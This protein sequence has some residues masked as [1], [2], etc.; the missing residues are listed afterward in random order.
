MSS[1]FGPSK[2]DPIRGFYTDLQKLQIVNENESGYENSVTES[3]KLK[4][5]FDKS[6]EYAQKTTDIGKIE[7]IEKAIQKISQTI[8]DPKTAIIIQNT[9]LSIAT[10]S[11]KITQ[12]DKIDLSY[13]ALLI[14]QDIHSQVA[15]EG[16][17]KKSILET[18][19]NIYLEL[20]DI[21]PSSALE[22]LKK[23]CADTN[24]SIQNRSDLKETISCLK[25]CYKEGLVGFLADAKPEVSF[26][27]CSQIEKYGIENEND[28]FQIALAIA[29]KDVKSIS[30]NIDKF[31]IQNAQYLHELAILIANKSPE[32]FCK[33][34][35]KFKIV[36]KDLLFKLAKIVADKSPRILCEYLTEFQIQTPQYLHELAILIAN[37]SPENFC[38][39]IS[40]FKIVD[41][42]L[43]FKLAKIVANKSPEILC[44]HLTEFQ[45]QNAQYLHE[46][47]TLIANESPET[48]CKNIFKFKKI[49]KDILFELAKIVADKNPKILCQYLTEFQI[50]TPQYLHEL[51][52]LIANKSPEILCQYLTE[53]QIQNSQYLHEL[54]TLIANESPETF[55]KNIFKF[56]KFG[57]DI[58]FELA[59]IVAD[60]NPKILCEYLAEF[61]IENKKH[62]YEIG[63]IIANKYPILFCRHV[64][65]FINIENEDL[66]E[67]AIIIADKEPITFCEYASKLEIN[68]EDTLF[69]IANSIIQTSINLQFFCKNIEKF[70]IK[71]P[72]K[73]FQLAK[74]V[75]T[76]DPDSFCRNIKKFNISNP[77][78]RYELAQLIATIR[79]ASLASNINY[80]DIAESKQRYELAKLIAKTN[81]A[82]VCDNIE[83]FN[84][85]DLNERLE[86]LRIASEFPGNAYVK[87]FEIPETVD[88]SEIAR[89]FAEHSPLN[90]TFFIKDF[91]IKN[92]EKL[93]EIAKTCL[94]STFDSRCPIENFSSDSYSAEKLREFNRIILSY[95][96][97]RLLNDKGPLEGEFYLGLDS[98]YSVD[99]LDID[100]AK[101]IYQS[102]GFDLSERITVKQLEKVLNKLRESD[103]I[104]TDSEKLTHIFNKILAYTKANVAAA[105][106]GFMVLYADSP[107]YHLVYDALSSKPENLP[108]KSKKLGEEKYPTSMFLPSIIPASWTEDPTNPKISHLNRF[109]Y[110]NRNIFKDYRKELIHIF[111]LTALNLNKSYFNFSNE[112][113]LELLSAACD[114]K[115]LDKTIISLKCILYFCSSLESKILNFI[116]LDNFHDNLLDNFKT[117]IK[118]YFKDKGDEFAIKLLDI[119]TSSRVSLGLMLYRK[120]QTDPSVL[121]S[122]DL[123]I[124]SVISGNF[125]QIRTDITNNPHLQY[126]K[127]QTPE[128]LDK[129]NA[130]E[131]E[132]KITNS[133]KT[134]SSINLIDFFK[135]KLNDHHFTEIQFPGLYRRLNPEQSIGS[136]NLRISELDNLIIELV[137]L[138]NSSNEKFKESLEEILLNWNENYPDCELKNDLKGLLK[139]INSSDSS[140]AEKAILTRDW[141]DLFLCGTDVYGSC[142]RIDGT[143]NENQCLMAYCLDGKNQMIAIKSADGKEKKTLARAILRLLWDPD[144]N[145]PVLFLERIYPNLSPQSRKEGILAAAKEAAKKLNCELIS[146]LNEPTPE[147]RKAQSFGS[148]CSHEYVDGGAGH[149]NGSFIIK[150]SVI[151]LS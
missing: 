37:K 27:I 134:P 14:C 133:G 61:Q 41:K 91:K 147:Q 72:E 121:E 73:C 149:S 99:Q 32:D 12:K 92:P 40:K 148:C 138:G 63:K 9:L 69:K 4:Y 7:K 57:K 105:L 67:I 5:L 30:K 15:E 64:N 19:E 55:C 2:Q 135:E 22:N 23:I 6:V 117:E 70:N 93:L 112:R 109:F 76:K 125:P 151:D 29:S 26:K 35:S 59:K 104:L 94:K 66:S 42:D 123:F 71:S 3:G 87:K 33:N 65:I 60:K 114:P 108:T 85:E 111:L 47:A 90:L 98:R 143:E 56:K 54:A 116:E 34:I 81:S 74:L 16:M 102:L 140:V 36:D 53:F 120:N 82:A 146:N 118:K 101:K 122:I 145:R 89:N 86:I 126:I 10:A 62:L 83:R 78:E 77:Q 44:Q 131:I 88:L 130:L 68:D 13:I 97:F 48:F 127:E 21:N 38:K 150:G 11:S 84:I 142:Q 132:L 103:P 1:Y 75:A 58:L 96:G 45:I 129:W 107:I 24:L 119:I 128:V 136:L 106:C 139:T 17:E 50:Q 137:N 144:N 49:G 110:E 51:A 20:V 95:V 52:T 141:E 43:L 25:K 80:F 31:Q 124:D 113:K 8:K 18:V 28:R 115:N 100:K 46:L 39:N 79:P